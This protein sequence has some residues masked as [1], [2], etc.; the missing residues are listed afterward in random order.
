MVNTL[1]L[2]GSLLLAAPAGAAFYPQ[3][4]VP[5]DN[6]QTPAKIALG[7]RLFSE[8]ALS[9]T[10][11]YS[12]ASCHQPHRHFTDGLKQAVGATGEQHAFNTPTLYNVAF[13]VSLGWTDQQITSLEH[14]HRVPLENR[15]PVEMGYSPTLAEALAQQESY[16]TAFAAVFASA[17]ST[18]NIVQAIASYVRTLRAPASAFDRYLFYDQPMTPEQHTGMDLFFSDRLG[19]AT[20]HAS[21]NFSGPIQHRTRQQPVVPEAVFHVTGVNNSYQ[22]FRAPTLRSVAHTAPYMHDG[23]LATLDEV[24]RHYQTTQRERIPKFRLSPAEHRALISFLKA[25]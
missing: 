4:L 8:T 19:C 6:P 14:Q 18:Q 10:G 23:S 9:V 12:C 5:G 2:L 3:P 11:T 7:K 22:A 24:L 15:N 20:C 16:R 13:N 17:P 1:I 25:L 21:L